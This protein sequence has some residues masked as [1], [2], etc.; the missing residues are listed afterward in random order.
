MNIKKIGITALAGSLVA[1]SAFAVEYSLSGNMTTKYSSADAPHQPE[2]SNGKGI[3]LDTDVTLSASGELD[4]GF[5][6]SAVQIWDTDA[7]V[8]NTSSQLTIGMGSMGTLQ[9]NNRAGSKANGIDDVMPAAY[10]ETW[11]GLSDTN[12]SF[13]G[14]QTLYGSIDYRAPTMDLGG[15]SVNAAI[16][17][18]PAESEDAP[19]SGGRTASS[20]PAVGLVLELAHESG[21]SIGAGQVKSDNGNNSVNGADEEQVTAYAKY[22]MGPISVG[23]QEAFQN[24]ENGGQDLASQMWSV[25]Y[26]AGDLSVS[27]GES[28]L[29]KEARGS[30][31][32][33]EA[34]LESIQVAY[35]MGA[36]TISG[37][38]SETGNANNVA[39]QTYEENEIAVSFAF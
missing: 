11:D 22:S 31:K 24:T 7:N 38:I 30:T 13:F 2:A 35:T 28:S 19:S 37:A 23:Y 15:I 14:N 5:T 27:Y 25:A 26:T 29:T 1:T 12:P 6:V 8:S 21:L 4:N 16:T 9:L 20:N 36:M 33:V 32:E 17:Y 34:D 3:G 10:N 39:G 18:D